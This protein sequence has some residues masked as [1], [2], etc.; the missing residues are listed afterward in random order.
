MDLKKI[1][2]QQHAMC[3]KNLPRDS[4]IQDLCDNSLSPSDTVHEIAAKA[5]LHFGV[6]DGCFNNRLAAVTL[7]LGFLEACTGQ[8]RTES[9]MRD[10]RQTLQTIPTRD[11]ITV[12]ARSHFP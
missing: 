12:W 1:L 7:V 4:S 10:L 3:Q 6:T 2:R 5:L 9:S 8:E 11:A